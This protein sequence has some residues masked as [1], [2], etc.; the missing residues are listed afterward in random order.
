M[1]L[2]FSDLEPPVI[3]IP[4]GWS[5][6]CGQFGLCSFMLSFVTS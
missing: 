4:Y 5:G 3:D 2:F 1:D 6:I